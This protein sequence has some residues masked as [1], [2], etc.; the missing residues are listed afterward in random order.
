[1]SF[2]LSVCLTIHLSNFVVVH[3]SLQLL[4]QY[5]MHGFETCN[6]VPACTEYVHKGIRILI[7]IKITEIICPWRTYL[8][9][10]YNTVVLFLSLQRL[11][12]YLRQGFGTCN[13]VQTCIEHVHKR[14]R[15][16]I[17]VC[18]LEWHVYKFW[19]YHSVVLFLS[20][21]LLLQ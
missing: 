18:P 10:P 16:L 5:L 15:F 6:T 13:T 9:W 14:N 19:Q 3:L 12:Q 7:Q 1:M 2:R 11:L 20:S 17:Q 21:Q 8:F 4:L